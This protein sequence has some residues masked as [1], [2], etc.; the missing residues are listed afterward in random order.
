MFL[1]IIIS[2]H[3]LQYLYS[4]CLVLFSQSPLLSQQWPCLSSCGM[5][6]HVTRPGTDDVPSPAGTVEE[7][8]MTAKR[9]AGY[10]LSLLNTS[11]PNNRITQLS[12][13]LCFSCCICRHLKCAGEAVFLFPLIL[14]LSSSLSLFLPLPL[15][16]FLDYAGF[17]CMNSTALKLP[18]LNTGLEHTTWQNRGG[19][20]GEPLQTL[21]CCKM[22]AAQQ[23]WPLPLLFCLPALIHKHTSSIISWLQTVKSCYEYHYLKTIATCPLKTCF[24]INL[25]AL[26]VVANT[27]LWSVPCCFSL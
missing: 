8:E 20:R 15:S 11:C 10:A 19:D 2:Q 25:F 16:C 24:N 3:G 18:D 14:S 23:P 7:R 21:L 12:L 4:H 22:E 1:L 27:V 17:Q 5:L 13:F 26:Y 9:E 6:G